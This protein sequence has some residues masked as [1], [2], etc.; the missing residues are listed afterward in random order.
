MA[1]WNLSQECKMGATYKKRSIN[2]IHYNNR[3]KEK[4]HMIILTDA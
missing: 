4:T 2:A 1:K 3:I